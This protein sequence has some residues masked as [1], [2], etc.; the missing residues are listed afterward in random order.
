MQS[1]DRP[2]ERLCCG[3]NDGRMGKWIRV[4]D[5]YCRTAHCLDREG[6]MRR[7]CRRYCCCDAEYVLF[8]ARSCVLDDVCCMLFC[9]VVYN[10]GVRSTRVLY[11]DMERCRY[12]KWRRSGPMCHWNAGEMSPRLR[13]R[14]MPHDGCPS[15]PPLTEFMVGQTVCS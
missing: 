2:R 1:S 15:F 11:P 5:A 14:W 7:G 12:S 3:G 6:E 13:N 10:R 8:L 9:R 4:G